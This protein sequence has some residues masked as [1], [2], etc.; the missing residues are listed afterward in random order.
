[1][2]QAGAATACDHLAALVCRRMLEFD[3]ALRWSLFAD[4]L[5]DDPGVRFER[6]A[7]KHRLWKLD[8]SHTK[9]ADR[10]PKR[11][12]VY[13]HS[14]HDAESVKAVKQPLTEFGIFREMSIKVQGLRVHRQQAE[15]CVVHLGDGPAEFMMKFSAYLKLLEI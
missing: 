15:H 4:P 7:V 13:A 2:H 6:I 9:I 5:G 1:V 14:D 12:V 8:V 10:R 11:G 3:D